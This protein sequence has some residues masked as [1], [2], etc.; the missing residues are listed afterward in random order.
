[1]Q[2]YLTHKSYDKIMYEILIEKALDMGTAALLISFIALVFS[3]TNYSELKNG[4]VV[5]YE[6]KKK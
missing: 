2:R 4:R 3:V 1:M 5:L 6:K